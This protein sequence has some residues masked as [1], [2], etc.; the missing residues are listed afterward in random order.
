MKYLGE[1]KIVHCDLAA[2]NVIVRA[3]MH[4]EVTDFGL[5]RVLNADPLQSRD[6]TLPILWAA[7]ELLNPKT[8]HLDFNVKTDVWAFGVTIWEIFTSGRQ[9][10]ADLRLHVYSKPVMRKLLYQHLSGGNLLAQPENW[11]F[12]LYSVMLSCKFDVNL[13][14][15]QVGAVIR[16]E[17]CI[18]CVHVR[19]N[20]N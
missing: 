9:P 15:I 12:E 20:I 3:E 2:R 8:K 13:G 11:T 16:V 6:V 7:Q 1:Q 18:F 14:F 4:V 5:A 19:L 17:I 10:Y